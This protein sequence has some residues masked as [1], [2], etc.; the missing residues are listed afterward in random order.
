MQDILVVVDVQNDFVTGAFGSEAARAIVPE[1]VDY[2]KNFDGPVLF[3]QD[4]H[5]DDYLETQEG[6]RLPVPHCLRGTE[7]W[8]LIDELEAL[9]KTP[10]IEKVTFGSV[11]LGQM[12]CALNKEEQVRSVSIAGLVTDICV[13]SNAMLAKAFLPEATIRVLAHLSAGTTKENHEL[14]LRA[15]ENVQ[16]DIIRE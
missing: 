7:G 16:V 9:R 10:S 5:G 13:I 12:L 11:E 6:R 15:L 1:L 4:T 3:T 2:V 8:N 14:A